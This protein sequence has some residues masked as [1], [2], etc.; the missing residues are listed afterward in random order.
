MIDFNTIGRR[1]KK[2]R[3]KLGMT[4]ETLAEKLNITTEYMSRIES[5][6]YKMSYSLAE[7]LCMVFKI[8]EAELYFG[9]KPTPNTSKIAVLYE[10]LNDKQKNII[11]SL[12]DEFSD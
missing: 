8:D 1:I 11:D 4:Q 6:R 5:G 10:E 7:Q 9:I 3:Q 12:F 2:N